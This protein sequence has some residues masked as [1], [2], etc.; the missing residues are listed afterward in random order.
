MTEKYDLAGAALK[1]IQ[2]RRS[3][4]QYTAEPVSEEHLEPDPG[5]G[6]PGTFR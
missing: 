6:A 2:D 4:R 5:G 1:V 3:V